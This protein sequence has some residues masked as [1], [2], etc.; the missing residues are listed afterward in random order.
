VITTPG[1]LS[2]LVALTALFGAFISYLASSEI[3][4]DE[5]FGLADWFPVIFGVMALLIGAM[6]LVNGRFVERVGLER[7]IMSLL[8]VQLIAS[9]A[10]VALSLATGGTPPFWAFIVVFAI[11]AGVQTVLTPN[12][13]SAA[14]RP[15]AHVAGS[16][17]ALL[18]MI[19]M[20]IGSVLGSFIDR[21][22]NGT[23]T[24]LSIGFL[25]A[26]AIALIATRMVPPVTAPT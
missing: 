25:C 22:F 26:G 18:G 3:I 4:F 16:A 6:M 24:P 15:L 8:V 17:A 11:V 19:P 1:T 9:V 10:L 7:L 20:I 23:V 13:N 5:V 14:M 21:A 12:I 2:Y